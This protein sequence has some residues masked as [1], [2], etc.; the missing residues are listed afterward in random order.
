MFGVTVRL[1]SFGELSRLEMLR[2]T[3]QISGGR[4]PLCR[5]QCHGTANERRCRLI[6]VPWSACRARRRASVFYSPSAAK[7]S[8]SKL[9]N[10]AAIAWRGARFF[11][12]PAV[13]E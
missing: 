6:R 2:R 11:G 3:N 1:M 8:L 7:L 9:V 4:D 10:H 12:E 13:D 5:T